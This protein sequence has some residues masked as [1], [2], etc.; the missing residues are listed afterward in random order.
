MADSTDYVKWLN[1]AEQD[2]RLIEIIY[3]EDLE[4]LEDSF[5]YMCQQASEKLLKALIVKNEKR[6]PKS[7]DLL[8]LLGLC[9]KHDGS[10]SKLTDALMVLNE[11][12]VSARYPSDFEDKRTIEEAKEAY[13]YIIE[14]R[15]AIAINL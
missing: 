2:L 5:C 6:V 10:L 4:G 1:R 15:K 3:N 7:H 11:Y 9:N 12:S 13:A 14:V 8:F